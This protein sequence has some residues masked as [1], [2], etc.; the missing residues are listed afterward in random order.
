MKKI[1]IGVFVLTLLISSSAYAR[2]RGENRRGSDDRLRMASSTMATSTRPLKDRNYFATSTKNVDIACVAAAVQKRE[3]A[4]QSA[5]KNMSDSV[6]AL[7]TKREEALLDAWEITDVQ[8]RRAE[9]KQ[10]HLDAKKAKK[11]AGQEHKKVKKEAWETFKKE[12]KA[13]GGSVGSEA[14]GESEAGE[15]IEI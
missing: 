2:E 10:A 5:W 1:I 7:L 8:Q 15:K 14:M 13:C 9:I 3:D 4:I 12:V 6:T 11:I